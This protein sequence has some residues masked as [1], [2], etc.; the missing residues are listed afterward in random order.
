MYVNKIY[1]QVMKI[2]EK[3]DLSLPL[4]AKNVG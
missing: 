1:N 4:A 3:Y 2:S